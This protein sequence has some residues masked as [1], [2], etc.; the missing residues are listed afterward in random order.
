MNWC[1]T[2]GGHHYEPRYDEVPLDITAKSIKSHNCDVNELRSL[3]VRRLYV[4]DIC[5]RCGDVVERN[6]TP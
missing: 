6:K 5:V 2:F 3:F 1:K 4:K